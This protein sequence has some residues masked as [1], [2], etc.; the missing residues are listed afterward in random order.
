MAGYVIACDFGTSSVKAILLDETGQA[1][2]RST[3]SYPTRYPA[4]G[5]AEQEPRDWWAAM[6]VCTRELLRSVPAEQVL[7]LSVCSHEMCCLPVDANG[8]PLRPAMIW[9]DTRAG[10]QARQLEDS[11]GAGAFYRRVGMRAAPNYTLPKIM[12]LQKYEPELY[13]KTRCFLNPKDY[14]NFHLCG[15]MATDPECAAYTHGADLSDGGWCMSTLQSAGI[16]AGK[17]PPI[18]AI[19]TVLGQVSKAAALETGLS[20]HTKVVMGTGDG[21]AATLG[22]AALDPGDAYT[23][24]GTSSWVCMVTGAQTMDGQRR[25]SKLRYLGT[26]RDSGTMQSGG[27]SYR[28]L[29]DTLGPAEEGEAHGGYREL[30]RLAAASPPGANGVLFLPYLM[31]ER[32]P[33]WDPAMCGAFIGLRAQNTRCDIYRSVMEGVSLHLKLILDIICQTNR[34]PLPTGMRLVGG[35]AG[36]ALWQQIFADVYGVPVA[37]VKYPGDAGALGVGVIAGTAAGLYGDLSFIR[38]MQPAAAV[39]VPDPA[40][41]QRYA[42]MQEIFVQAYQSMAGLSHSLS[43]LKNQS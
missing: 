35:G 9:A 1:A 34:I 13:R 42:R 17:L 18:Y 31:G 32:A 3:A 37:T 39:C 41:R 11:V 5:R 16:D 24:L 28:W 29:K 38:S 7:A 6:A 23:N 15:C 2:A 4:P 20:P 40:N 43:E 25:I 36:S 21:G 26:L 22:T 19:G 14:I 8:V 33:Y 12:W 30:N 10:E 27:D